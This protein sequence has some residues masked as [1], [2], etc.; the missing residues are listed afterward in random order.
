[1][2]RSSKSISTSL[3]KVL[4][5]VVKAVKELSLVVVMLKVLVKKYL[6]ITHW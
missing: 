3:V 4:N 5:V 2:S 1:M 6:K